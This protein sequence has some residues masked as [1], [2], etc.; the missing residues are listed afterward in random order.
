MKPAVNPL[1]LDIPD[2]FET[3]R[4]SIRCPKSGDGPIVNQAITE[5]LPRLALWFPWAQTAPTPEETEANM[6]QARVKYLERTD[7]RLLVFHK[8]TGDLVASSGL[9]RINWNVP[10]FEI[11]YW[12]TAKYEGQGLVTEAVQGIA[13]FAFETLRA[14]RIEIRCAPENTR[15]ARVA[16]KCGFVLEARL[17]NDARDVQGDLRDTL[18]WARAV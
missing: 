4:L 10:K 9:H 15:S 11:G 2:A 5:S 6:R 12:A 18:I 1:L 3:A 7:L 17:Q 14:A 8:K 13:E 16:Q